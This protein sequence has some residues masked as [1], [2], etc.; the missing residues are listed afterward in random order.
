MSYGDTQ[1]I[2]HCFGKKRRSKIMLFSNVTERVKLDKD[3]FMI[4]N[5]RRATESN[6][7]KKKKQK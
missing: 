2:G 6:K 3:D 7:F 1:K 5:T 4:L